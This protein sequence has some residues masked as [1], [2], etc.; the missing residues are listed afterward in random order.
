MS[1]GF[2]HAAKLASGIAFRFAAVSM[3]LGQKPKPV[4]DNNLRK[5]APDEW[6]TYGRDYSETHFSPLKQINAGNVGGLGLA[7]SWETR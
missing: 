6:I 7:W 4:D 2:G 3:M 1:S 5:A